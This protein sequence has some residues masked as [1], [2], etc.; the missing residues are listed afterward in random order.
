M[1]V[2]KATP[3]AL[4]PLVDGG[5]KIY[6]VLD[7]I[8]REAVWAGAKDIGIVISPWQSDLI[9]KYLADA[10]QNILQDELSNIEFITQQTPMGFGD[11]V[12]QARDFVAD[13]P[14][15][16]LLGDHIQIPDK[17]TPACGL[18]LAQA[19]DSMDAQA[20]VGMQAVTSE[21]L[22]RVGVAAGVPVR[23]NVYHCTFFIEKP[24]PETARQKLQTPGLPPDNFLAHCGIYIFSPEIFDCLEEVKAK[25]DNSADELELADAQNL[26]LKKYPKKYFLYKIN[27]LVYDTGTP[28][29]Y[30]R[31]QAA[32]RNALQNL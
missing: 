13:E 3:K 7:V 21:K 30:A 4:F 11:A 16:L 20:L 32:F 8:C 6:T 28:E 1:P 12:L 18:Q 26:L 19:F 22:S 2:T 24:D 9:K 14:F 17:G 10:R 5:G 15:M 31:T 29:G 27:G 23:Q 25:I